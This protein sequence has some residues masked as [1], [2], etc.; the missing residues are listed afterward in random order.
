MTVRSRN[1]ARFNGFTETMGKRRVSRPNS[2]TP[3]TLHM[4]VVMA[5]L[6]LHGFTADGAE[7]RLEGFL[8]THA[9]RSPGEVVRVIT[10]RG[11]RSSGAPVLQERVRDALTGSMRHRVAD[12]AVDVGGGAYLVKLPG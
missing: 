3:R 6:D 2:V 4:S 9:V 7:R 1:D 8:E 12:W 10:G 5:E 11:T